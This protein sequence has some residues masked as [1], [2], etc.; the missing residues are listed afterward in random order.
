MS[1]GKGTLSVTRYRLMAPEAAELHQ[2]RDLTWQKYQFENLSEGKNTAVEIRAGWVLPRELAD[3]DDHE[4]GYWDFSH[5]RL[6][7]GS[8]LRLR[9]ERRRI[10]HEFFQIEFK[11]RLR[12]LTESTNESK[13]KKLSMQR[14]KEEREM[15]KDE[16]LARALPQVS[17]ID[18][19][20]SDREI[21]YV[22]SKAKANLEIF[23]TFF[24]K[25]FIH[26]PGGVMIPLTPINM[27]F[28]QHDWEEISHD[29]AHM[30]NVLSQVRKIVPTQMS[31]QE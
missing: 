14:K 10:P 19:Y 20:W 4:F 11:K 6:S 28:N 27:G 29:Q 12:T 9:I 17:H 7:Q 3:N 23:E 18:A 22:Y 25:S 24:R 21:L 13:T 16:L 8:F 1:V 15:L 30:G 5:L 31:P 26:S 2:N